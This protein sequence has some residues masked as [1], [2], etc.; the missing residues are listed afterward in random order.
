M[1]RLHFSWALA[2]VLTL[3]LVTS[4]KKEEP[5]P[6]DENELITTVRLKFTE[7]GTTTTQT[8]DWKD[9]DGEGGSAPTIASVGLKTNRTYKLEVEFLNESVTP[10]DNITE[11]IKEEADE[12]LVVVIPQPAGL[13]TYT[14]D[15]KDSRNYPIGLTGKIVTT[16]AATG[17][18]QVQLRHQPPVGGVPVKNGTAT[19]GS[20]DANVT[21]N[22]VVAP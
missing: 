17:T 16:S 8:F 7:N 1:N 4:C 10:V 12:H 3:A 13:L 22:V 20:D 9:L 19:P 15:D 6:E 21:F 11:E 14:Y 2:L 18:I 5:A